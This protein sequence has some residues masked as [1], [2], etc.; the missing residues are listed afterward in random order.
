MPSSTKFDLL[1]LHI[2]D[3]V[4]ARVVD[5]H[6]SRPEAERNLKH[7]KSLSCKRRDY[8]ILKTWP[9]RAQKVGR[10]RYYIICPYIRETMRF[11]SS[12]S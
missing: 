9:V 2:L 1:L 10:G 8:K 3:L 4:I 5:E 7:E 11:V 6:A 12:Q